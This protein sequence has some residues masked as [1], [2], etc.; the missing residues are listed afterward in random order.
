[1][2][3]LHCGSRAV[4]LD[5]DDALLVRILR[6]LMCSREVVKIKTLPKVNNMRRKVTAAGIG[7]RENRP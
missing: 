2:I 7:A 4:V 1:M 6:C 3:C 5:W